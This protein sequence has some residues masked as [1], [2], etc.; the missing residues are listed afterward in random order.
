M[1]V[2]SK[3]KKAEKEFLKEQERVAK[4][5][6]KIAK[7]YAKLKSGSKQVPD[8][9]VFGNNTQNN[10]HYQPATNPTPAASQP[11]PY[12]APAQQ[13]VYYN[14]PVE[15]QHYD[16]DYGEYSEG[17]G[18]DTG[19]EDANYDYY[20]EAPNTQY[21]NDYNQDPEYHNYDNNY[22]SFLCHLD[23]LPSNVIVFFFS[24]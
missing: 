15:E 10:S 3:Q 24:T 2:K 23:S 1:S 5:Q 17:Y 4:E 12:V 7:K 13:P 22:L 19:Y 14:P 16:T 9:V 8:S 11:K 18:D 21:S 6:Q 20:N